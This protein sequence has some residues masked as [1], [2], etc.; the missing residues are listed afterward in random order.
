MSDFRAI[1]PSCSSSFDLV[2]WQAG[3]D[4]NGHT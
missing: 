4:L 3:Y 1:D 2:P